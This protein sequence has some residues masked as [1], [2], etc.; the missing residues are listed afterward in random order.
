MFKLKGEKQSLGGVITDS[1][2]LVNASWAANIVVVLI[3][4]LV[5]ISM[6]LV[7]GA[8]FS[9]HIASMVAVLKDDQATTAV[10]T[11]SGAGS[12]KLSGI[13]LGAGIAFF[14]IAWVMKIA[15]GILL[16]SCWNVATSGSANLTNACKV[17]FKYFY[18]YLLVMLFIV[19]LNILMH[20]VQYIF[21]FL[22]WQWLNVVVAILTQLVIYYLVVRISLVEVAA[23]TEECGIQGFSNSWCVVS[24]NWWRVVASVAFSSLFYIVVF[25]LVG[26]GIFLAVFFPGIAANFHTTL[27]HLQGGQWPRWF[28]VLFGIAAVLT[29][30]SLLFTLP[31]MW[32]SNQV[33]LYNDLKHRSQGKD[34]AEE[35]TLESES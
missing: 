9:K 8:I 2:S 18:V 20:L 25:Y 35:S 32:A 26:L 15:A 4:L 3:V 16:R 7:L 14:F 17:G 12:T 24:G 28:G 22:H 33:V 23:V 13:F 6:W 31:S 10:V 34:H 30:V 27:A 29:M 1:F 11:S 19:A 21:H 5:V